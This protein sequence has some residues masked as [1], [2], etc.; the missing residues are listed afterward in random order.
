M[1]RYWRT[2]RCDTSWSVTTSQPHP[3][4]AGRDTRLL[5][6]VKIVER[7]AEATILDVIDGHIRTLRATGHV[8]LHSPDGGT[9]WSIE[10]RPQ[11]VLSVFFRKTRVASWH[12]L[13]PGWDLTS[14]RKPVEKA[15]IIIGQILVGTRASG[16]RLEDLHCSYMLSD[17]TPTWT[18]R[19]G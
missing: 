7:P 10:L 14:Q 9:E 5:K 15:R 2:R 6:D 16:V 1:P 4:Y 12:A 17:A 19:A 3:L 13:N 18:D 8:R 11:G